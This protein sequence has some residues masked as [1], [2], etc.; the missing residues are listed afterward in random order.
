MAYLVAAFTVI[1]IITFVFI[2]TIA[3]RQR[4]LLAEIAEL[5]SQLERG[6]E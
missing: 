5:R 3:N 2:L 6:D 4:R 1:W